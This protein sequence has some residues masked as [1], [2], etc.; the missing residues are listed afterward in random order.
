[1]PRPP[2]QLLPSPDTAPLAQP[3]I[4]LP[5]ALDWP[6]LPDAAGYRVQLDH[7][8]AFESLLLN[9]TTESSRLQLPDLADGRYWLQL[10]GIDALGLEGRDAVL[11]IVIDAR[12]EPPFRIAPTD[13]QVVRTALPAFAWS[14]VDGADAYHF[15]LASDPD[16]G[17]LLI[18]LPDFRGTTFAP[19]SLPPG[20]YYWRLATLAGGERG[21]FSDTLGFAL[22]PIPDPQP[23]ELSETEISFRW[24]AGLSG[25]RYRFQ[26]AR[27]RG[28]EDLLVDRE[29]AEPRI[30]VERPPGGNEYFMRYAVI[31]EDGEQGPFSTVQRIVLPIDDYTPFVIFGIISILLLL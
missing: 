16:F 14:A 15:Q 23:P 2:R 28:F 13:S 5:L 17:T 19:E 26:L 11:R 6:D 20:E 31:D 30:T 1:V 22:R 12:P 29:L 3:L 4:R 9:V 25:E 24:P 18:D 10:R 8:T 21:P 7:N 27:D